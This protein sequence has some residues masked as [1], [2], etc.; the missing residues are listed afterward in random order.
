MKTVL[1]SVS[2]KIGLVEFLQV[3]QTFDSLRIIATGSTAK[4]IEEAG[5]SCETVESLTGFPEIL[6]GRVKT[7]HPKVFGGILAK[8]SVSHQA[9]LQAHQIPQ[10]DYVIVNLYPFE[11][12]AKTSALEAEII[13]NI[14]IGGVALIRAAAK[15]YQRVVV[16]PGREFYPAVI[17]ELHETQGQLTLEFHR[18]LARRA[19]EQTAYYDSLI[20]AYLFKGESEE[21]PNELSLHFGKLETLRYGENPHQKAAWYQQVD[22]RFEKPF[23]QLQGKEMSSN[24]IVDTHAAF[25]ILREFP[26]DPA[27]C[28][29]KHNNPCGVAMGKTVEEAFQKAYEADP[30]SAFGGIF[31]FN[32]TVSK[33]IA[34]AITQNFV[35]IVMA[36]DFTPEAMAVFA[37]KKNIRVLQVPKLLQPNNKGETW[38]LK[39]LDEFGLLLQETTVSSELPELTTVTEQTLPDNTLSDVAFAWAIVKHLTSNAIVVVKNGQTVG[40]GVGQTSRIAS[41]EIALRQAGENASGAVLASDGFFPATDNIEAAAKAGISV[42]VQPGGSIKDP[43]VIEAADQHG[44]VM[45]MTHER[46]FKH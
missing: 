8:E 36:P 6:E 28:I 10:F 4:Y 39:D 24:N 42:I 16:L 2:D 45:V 14:D 44:M 43:E 26:Q 30:I 1:A 32:R 34:E 3:L 37:A 19:F 9:H 40:F 17:Q 7:L 25:K 35:E 12:V 46:C 29:I 5:L 38:Q 21:M 11:S 41:M 23:E 33:D 31:G 18:M 20:S 13:E 15:N 22:G 27:A